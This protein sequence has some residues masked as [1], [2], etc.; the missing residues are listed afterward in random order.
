MPVRLR[1]TIL[2]TALVVIIVGILCGSIYYFSY[3]SRIN[4]IKTRLINRSKTTA[5]FLAQKEIF[6]QQLVRRID[7]LTTLS[8]KKKTIA[9]FDYKNRKIYSY[10]D[11][12][13]DTIVIDEK[14]LNSARKKSPVFLESGDKE[15]VIYYYDDTFNGIVVVSAAEDTEGKQELKDLLEILILSFLTSIILV[16]V[17]GFI[18]SSRLLR[19]IKKITAD[20]EEISV[21]SLARRINTGTSKDEWYYLA[22]TLN[23]LL[24]RLQDSF[25]LQ[26]RFIAHASHELSTPLTSVSSQLEISLQRE[27]DAV[28]Y[29]SV[30]Q[31]IY[32]DVQHM[33]KLTQTLLEFAKASGSSSGLEITMLRIDEII[34]ELPAEIAKLNDSYS[35]IVNYGKLPEDERSL[36][37]YGNAPL[38]STAIRNLVLNACKYSV[39]HKAQIKL[40]VTDEIIISITD[41][42]KGIPK[43]ELERIFQP[44]YRVTES[45][46]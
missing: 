26:S 22:K 32:A 31:S 46:S 23:Q 40:E 9:A 44:F 18:F 17:I 7:S 45:V 30:M 11:L 15:E 29:R 42:G 27:R 8:L 35:V 13:G 21:Q 28:E 3:S 4:T 2:F 6:D 20:L 43:E 41:K 19:P 12:P 38:L 1:I 10:S 25:E 37:V 36:V 14:L 34:L 16:I 24:N 5:R 33:N 39:D